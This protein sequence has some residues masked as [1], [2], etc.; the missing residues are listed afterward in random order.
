MDG[1][2]WHEGLEAWASRAEEK[3]Q[4]ERERETDAAAP[5]DL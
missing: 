5:P 2:A 4:A 1:V 3:R